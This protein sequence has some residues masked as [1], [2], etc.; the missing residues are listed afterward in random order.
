MGQ[1][2]IK[3][4]VAK[5]AKVS[6]WSQLIPVQVLLVE[7]E[8]GTWS[9]EV[10]SSLGAQARGWWVGRA[11]AFHV[12]HCQTWTRVGRD[13]FGHWYTNF[14]NRPYPLAQICVDTI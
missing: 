12:A 10:I 3:C 11:A 1:R 9:H 5:H 4:L 6:P 8:C 14:W 7:S 13:G 2:V